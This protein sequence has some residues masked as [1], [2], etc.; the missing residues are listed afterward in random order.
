MI[1]LFNKARIETKML[2]EYLNDQYIVTDCINILNRCQVIMCVTGMGK[3]LTTKKYPNL[4]Y[5]LDADEYVMRFKQNLSRKEV[6]KQLND[7][8]LILMKKYRFIFTSI[9]PD[10]YDILKTHNIPHIVCIP[11]NK[12]YHISQ[13]KKYRHDPKD[14]MDHLDK[15]W[16]AWILDQAKN[17]SD[18]CSCISCDCICDI[19]EY[20]TNTITMEVVY[21]VDK[22]YI[23]LAK[24]SIN[25]VLHYN[26]NVHINI[27]CEDYIEELSQYMQHI[28]HVREDVRLDKSFNGNITK[29]AY[30]KLYYVQL[31]YN[32]VLHLDADTLCFKPLNDLWNIDVKYLGLIPTYTTKHGMYDC[33]YR[34]GIKTHYNSGVMLMNLKN[35]RTDNFTEKC[36]SQMNKVQK[37]FFH[38]ETCINLAYDGKITSLDQKYNY[39]KY[40]PYTPKISDWCIVHY[41]GPDKSTMSIDYNNNFTDTPTVV[42]CLDI[43]YVEMA[44]MSIH[45]IKKHNPHINIIIISET[46][47]IIDNT[48]NIIT[49]F[50][51]MYR[52]KRDHE[53]LS[54][55][56]Y[57]RLHLPEILKDLD[58]CIYL[59][60]DT[61]CFK[62]LDSLWNMNIPYIGGCEEFDS[63][64]ITSQK[65]DLNLAYYINSGM[66]LM[67]LKALREDNFTEKCLDNMFNLTT[68]WWFHDQT[69]INKNYS[70][71]ITVLDRTYNYCIPFKM[72]VDDII[73]MNKPHILHFIGS[74]SRKTL[75][76][77]IYNTININQP[78]INTINGI[79]ALSHLFTI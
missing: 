68:T 23:E 60:A 66:L 22:N 2:D 5:D 59:D 79:D 32:K 19:I 72:T 40:M 38:D 61:L 36:L 56:A 44:K 29:S 41:T 18:L 15:D 77:Q 64:Q 49:T 51:N 42:Y 8:L 39:W 55:A 37:Y 10:M 45:S 1:H 57:F 35:L 14:Y 26:P 28:I 67:N 58:K 76:N 3:S 54:K 47:I 4:C 75:M 53:L 24:K 7:R 65:H 73:T 6:K 71:K 46:P 21:C 20:Y 43:K 11:M 78:H 27:V 69:L 33:G 17:T 50:D 63:E 31:P 12:E 13:M 9:D 62:S 25:S 30:L 52:F 34:W 70:D 16:N 74:K 48:I